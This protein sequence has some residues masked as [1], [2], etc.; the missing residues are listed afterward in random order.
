MTDSGDIRNFL[1]QSQNQGVVFPALPPQGVLVKHF[2]WSL[3]EIAE[4][5]R[6]SQR[7]ED[8]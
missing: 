2:G 5:I 1:A 6:H 4:S 8:H 7:L 3:L